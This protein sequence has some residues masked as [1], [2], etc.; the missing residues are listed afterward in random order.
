MDYWYIRKQHA[1][2]REREKEM[3]STI[4]KGSKG[5]D[6]EECQVLLNK[7]GFKTSVD[8][9]FGSGTETSV[10][11]FQSSRGLTADGIVGPATWSALED[12]QKKEPVKFSD[13]AKFFP[14]M[15]PQVYK[16]S[17]A[18]CPS[19]PPGMSLK[20]IG[21]E[22]TNCVLF[23]AWLLSAALPVT[24]TKEQWSLWMVSTTDSRVPS[25]GPRVIMDWNA[26]SP[27]PGDGPWLVQWFTSSGGHSLIVLDEDPETGK[28]LTLEANDSINGAGWNQIGPLREVA[29]PGINWKDKVTQTWSNRVYS[30]RAVHIVRIAITGVRE[31][32]ESA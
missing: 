23:T 14:Q 24:F 22:T 2:L 11:A 18:Q 4:K 16:L 25:Y 17:G 12:V 1:A 6:V 30:K 31:W 8:G 28:I 13:V 10:K 21:S 5:P 19:N 3:P 15:F 20:R 9:V 7:N 27:A 29:N 32:L 26:G